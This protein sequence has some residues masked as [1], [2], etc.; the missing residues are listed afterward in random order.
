MTAFS[1]VGE[2][3]TLLD[4]IEERFARVRQLLR[5]LARSDTPDLGGLV[6]AE[7]LEQGGSVTKDE[8][9]RIAAAHGM[10]RR[11]LGGFFRQ[12]GKS[13]LH[14]LPGDR[15][16]LTPYGVE[17]ARRHIERKEPIVY[18]ISEPSFMKIAEASFAEEWE[19]DED[20]VY[21]TL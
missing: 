5:P 10:D 2:A 8:L 4:E 18:E 12:S 13:S 3:L 15:V 16:L 17:Q 7:V 6:L 14:V 19:S 1:N 21:D 9:Y 20:S 11:G